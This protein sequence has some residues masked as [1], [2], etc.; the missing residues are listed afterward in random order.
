MKRAINETTEAM[1]TLFS[2]RAVVSVVTGII[3]VGWAYA[4]VAWLVFRAWGDSGQFG[5][6]FGAL[7]A[8]FSGL[9]FAAVGSA[10]WIQARHLRLYMRERG[11]PRHPHSD[12]SIDQGDQECEYDMGMEVKFQITSIGSGDPG[13]GPNFIAP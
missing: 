3:V 1:E 7:N 8:M 4:T 6:T 10:L 12:G 5:D 9:G 2:G 13:V 11:D